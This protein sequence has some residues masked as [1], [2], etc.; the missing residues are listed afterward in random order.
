MAEPVARASGWDTLRISVG[1]LAPIVAR[2]VIVRRPRVV[3]V[4]EKIDADRRAGRLLGR[5]ADRYGPGPLLLRIPGRSVAVVLDPEDVHRV[6]AET[7]EPFTPDNREKHAALAHFQPAGVLISRG[8][9]RTERR[10]FNEAV[11]ETGRPVH[12]LAG[13]VT[14]VIA[15]EVDR[16]D[17]DL[18]W[19]AF[20]AMWWRIVRRT[21]LG[22]DARDDHELTDLLRSLRADA[23][24]AYLK[25][26]RR[27][28]RERFQSR[29]RRYLDRARPGSL[30]E[31][32]AETPATDET[33]PDQQ[34]PHWLFAFDAAGIAS[35]R[36]LALLAAHPAQL[37]WARTD[38]SRPDLP[39]LRA[40]VL[41]SV[42][43]WPTTPAILRDATRETTWRGRVLPAGTAL[44]IVTPFFHRD[45]RTL[46]YAN[47]FTPDIWLDG[48]AEHAYSLV[49]FSS[50][51]GACP[52]RDLVLFTT[53]TLLAALL[54]RFDVRPTQPNRLDPSR[55]MPGTLNPFTLGFRLT[56]QATTHQ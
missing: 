25:P 40:C 16:V 45:E 47:T 21:V 43:L 50:G 2:G 46:P 56:S 38:P 10:R 32:V 6:L 7:P 37:Q 41:E 28:V 23:N 24:W 54:D 34:V 17:G 48:R 20:N 33:E 14:A 31:L 4:L 13:P 29:L 49:P 35:F 8:R 30:A 18:S 9:A 27:Q 12:R 44:L 15:D 1:V 5:I 51:P 42:R 3:A 11:L 22:D 26:R 19:D 52:G 55:P 39:R 53:S 36:T